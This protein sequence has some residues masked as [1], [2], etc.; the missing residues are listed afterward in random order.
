MAGIDSGMVIRPGEGA[1]IPALGMIHKVDGERLTGH[2]LVM[3]GVIPPGTLIHPHTHTREDECSFVLDGELQY[4]VGDAV[5]T[6]GPGSYVPKPRGVRH[7]FWNATAYPARVMEM[8]TP[9]TFDLY[10]DELG[11]LFQSHAH[12]LDDLMSAFDQL[13]ARYG[14]T[15][16]WDDVPMLVERYGAPAPIR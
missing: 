10:Y 11:A 14:V 8:H 5:C 3:E 13:A 12:S 1:D 2:L 9:A 4:L 16:H 15:V 6:V 7:A